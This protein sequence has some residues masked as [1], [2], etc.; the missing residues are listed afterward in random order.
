MAAGDPYPR[1]RTGWVKGHKTSTMRGSGMGEPGTG[2][3]HNVLPRENTK[4]DNWVDVPGQL[5]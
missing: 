2:G 1:S 3:G 4:A 5:G